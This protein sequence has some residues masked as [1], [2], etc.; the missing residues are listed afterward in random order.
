MANGIRDIRC[1]KCG[2][3]ENVYVNVE[4]KGV[5]NYSRK[6][7][8][9][10]RNCDQLSTIDTVSQKVQCK[11]CRAVE[12]TKLFSVAKVKCPKCGNKSFDATTG[13]EF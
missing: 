5:G 13:V 2:N 11:N 8:F 1:R 3:I 9:F 10:C 12:L 6:D 4:E 7:T